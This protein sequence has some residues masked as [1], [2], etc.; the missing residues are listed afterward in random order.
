[1]FIF[2]LT[3]LLKLTG[4]GYAQT[5]NST[6][7]RSI[8]FSADSLTKAAILDSLEQLYKLHFAYNPELIEARKKVNI[9]AHEQALFEVLKAL[10]N[11]DSIS[12]RAIENQV[13]FYP[14]QQEEQALLASPF[15]I[16]R[17]EII[18]E[19]REEPISY[20]NI[21][22][23]G[24]AVGSMSNLEGR[25]VIK[26]PEK[27]AADTLSFSSIGYESVFL[28]LAAFGNESKTIILNRKNYQ[29]KSIDVIRYNPEFVLNMLEENRLKNYTDQFMVMTTFYREIVK[30]NDEFTDIS[31]AV[32]QV[33]K[34]P[35][36]R[37]E[38]QDHVKFLKGR[39]G[40]STQPY[41]DIRFRLKG[42]PYYITKLDV[43][44]N[45]ESFI[46]PEYR[47]LYKY[48]FDRKTLIDN[49]E[50]AI[51]S[52][53][54]IANL[55]DMLFE[56][57]LYVD[58]ETWA[59]A[60]VE[61]RYTKQGLREARNTLIHKEPKHCRA[62][63][64]ELS[65][66]VQYKYLGNKWILLSARSA[67]LVKI[68]NREQKLKTRFESISEI[69]TTNIDKENFEHFTRREI[70]RSNEIFSDKIVEYDHQFWQNYNIIHPE[71]ELTKALKNFNNQNLVI[72]NL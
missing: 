69:L 17:G 39:K 23:V 58:T 37:D 40:A 22:I 10:I 54:P 26:I 19:R 36:H 63:P 57:K 59:L 62:I 51:I 53:T 33:L 50:T 13:I 1:M 44:K 21:G 70:F 16:I 31:E 3:G 67:M 5:G 60:R 65:H 6:L 7:T 61:F 47:H 12:I 64:T 4:L 8:S 56:G 66:T 35:Y 71:E 20:C 18:D 55:R 27:Y 48:E 46:N 52:F 15:I 41:N 14:V 30:E 2:L 29:L 34:A 9:K 28:P 43:V 25:F 72:T 68:N 32:L 24:K 38:A 49:R 42:G 45:H 11:N